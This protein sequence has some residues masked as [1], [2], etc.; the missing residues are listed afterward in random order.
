[1]QTI[2]AQVPDCLAQLGEEAARKEKTSP[3]QFVA[4]TPARQMSV[5]KVSQNM[6]KRAGHG[7]AS[8]LDRIRS[9]VP[10]VSPVPGDEL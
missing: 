5:W 10:G 1:M 2:Q 7:S 3:G 8:E 6:E 9:K 4:L